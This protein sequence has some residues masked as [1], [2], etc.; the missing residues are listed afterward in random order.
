MRAPLVINGTAVHHQYAG[1]RHHHGKGRRRWRNCSWQ[2]WTSAGYR[3]RAHY[4]QARPG[5]PAGTRWCGST[6]RASLAGDILGELR[7]GLPVCAGRLAPAAT[8]CMRWLGVARRA[9]DIAVAATRRWKCWGE[10]LPTTKRRLHACRQRDRHP[11][12]PLSTRLPGCSTR[13]P[14]HHRIVDREGVLFRAIRAVDRCV[15]Y[16]RRGH[17]RHR[18]NASGRGARVPHSRRSV[19]GASLV[20][21]NASLER[22]NW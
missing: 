12:E 8:H 2:T 11:H 15:Q 20:A 9:H 14:R 16:W 17:W 7:Q 22:T 6:T 18:W 13:R 3:D 1:A 10:L 21:R 5:S 19:R 4:G